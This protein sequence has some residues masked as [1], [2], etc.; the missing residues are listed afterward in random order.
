MPLLP[1]SYEH[2]KDEGIDLR[3]TTLTKRD[4]KLQR[5]S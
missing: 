3:N 1:E 5:Y 4:A 2:T